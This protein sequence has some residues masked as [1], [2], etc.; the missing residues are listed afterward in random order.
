LIDATGQAGF[1]YVFL[2]NIG[3]RQAALAYGSLDSIMRSIII[4]QRY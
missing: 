3:G 4:S 2:S 1:M